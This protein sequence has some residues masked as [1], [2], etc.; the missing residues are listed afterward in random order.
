MTDFIA[1]RAV[2]ADRWI[3]IDL[4]GYRRNL[5]LVRMRVAPAEV[6]A[7]VKNDAYGH[8]I[9]PIVSAALAEGVTTIGVLDAAVGIDLRRAGVPPA[10][11]LFAWLFG[12]DEN[13]RQA[14]EARIDLG[15]S[16][17]WQLAAIVDAVG[18]IPARIHVKIDTGL[19][20]AGARESEWP[21][22]VAAARAAELS[23]AVTIE[24]VWTH[25]AEASDIEDSAAIAR[26]DR[27]IAVLGKG[28]TVVRH[29]AAS[30]A[31]YLRSDSRFD[32]VR[33]GAFTYGIAPGDGVTS[34]ALGLIP[35][36][37]LR[38]R[39]VGI[40]D[41]GTAVIPIGLV[42][43][44]PSLR[45]A[46]LD[47]AHAESRVPILR[48]D[49]TTTR[50]LAPRAALGDVVTLFGSN[51]RSEPT[52]QEWADALGTIGEEIVVRLSPR[53]ERRHHSMGNVLPTELPA[54]Q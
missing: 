24:G 51:E 16:T 25:I 49:P 39:V 26:F 53:I 50:I 8:G 3:D 36:M 17:V 6:M 1:T 4:D 31:S 14:I 18:D 9:G 43:G 29:L 35:V 46:H 30:A 19:G 22:L 12:A 52:L 7:V 10:I 11:V 44:M 41:D 34:S 47:A 13:Y 2:A 32:L 15:V 20:R 28:D 48:V 5:A 21:A 40:H 45:G 23:G 33:V 27:A 54:A 42:D 38:A 37:A